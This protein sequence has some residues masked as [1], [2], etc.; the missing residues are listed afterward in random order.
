MIPGRVLWAAI[1]GVL[2]STGYILALRMGYISAPG[3]ADVA[4]AALAQAPV[5]AAAAQ[6]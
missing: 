1:V 5:L 3:A 2:F 6:G 4:N